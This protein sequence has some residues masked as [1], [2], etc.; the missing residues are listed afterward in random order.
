[1]IV[2]VQGSELKVLH[3][4]AKTIPGMKRMA[5]ESCDGELYVGYPTPQQLNEYVAKFGLREHKRKIGGKY[6]PLTWFDIIYVR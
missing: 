2:D 1:M 4:A 5:V 6:G 3:G